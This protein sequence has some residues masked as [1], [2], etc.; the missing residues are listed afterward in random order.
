MKVTIYDIAKA[1]SVSASTVSRGLNGSRLIEEQLVQAIQTKAGEMGYSQRR[2]RKQRERAI[3]TVKIVLPGGRVDRSLQLFYDFGELAEAIR[4]GANPCRVQLIPEALTSGFEAFSH[5]KGG[6]V[7]AFIFAFCKP[8]GE[9]MEQLEERGVPFIFL[10]RAVEEANYVAGDHDAGMG[11]LVE[12]LLSRRPSICP[13]FIQLGQKSEV[14]SERRAGLKHAL[15]RAG[16]AFDLRKDVVTFS[17]PDAMREDD[18][19]GLLGRG[20]NTFFCYNDLTALSLMQRL[21]RLGVQ[22]PGDVSITGFDNSPVRALSY[23][24]ITTVDM[25]VATFGIKA[26]EWLVKQVVERFEEPLQLRIG[27]CLIPGGTT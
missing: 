4:K 15:K 5:K 10:N 23:P 11:L 20:V 25:P 13:A 24:L 2:I 3:L 26:G 1:L 21:Q 12:H 9:V 22:T 7:D 8:G 16:V 17:K 27:G 6:D 14:L 19:S 18:L